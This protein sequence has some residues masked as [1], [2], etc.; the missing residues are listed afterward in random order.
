MVITMNSICMQS[1]N[2]RPNSNCSRVSTIMPALRG[3]SAGMPFIMGAI[4]RL[5]TKASRMRTCAGTRPSPNTGITQKA[6]AMRMK[7]HHH[8]PSQAV[9]SAALNDSREFI[10]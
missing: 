5:M 9:S 1:P 4:S 7:G 6:A 2:S 10:R 3:S 8:C